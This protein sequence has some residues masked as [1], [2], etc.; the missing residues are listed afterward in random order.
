MNPAEDVFRRLCIDALSDK[1]FHEDIQIARQRLGIEVERFSKGMEKATVRNLVEG[2]PGQFLETVATMLDR[3]FP[4]LPD[5]YYL[6]STAPGP[7]GNAFVFVCWALCYD[8]ETIP[9]PSHVSPAVRPPVNPYI[10]TQSNIMALALIDFRFSIKN[11]LRDLG[12]SEEKISILLKRAWSRQL[13]E[14][15]NQGHKMVFLLEGS[16][17]HQMLEDL[18]KLFGLPVL[19]IPRHVTSTQ[20]RSWWPQIEQTRDAAYGKQ[21]LP[22]KRRNP[23]EKEIA[24]MFGEGKSHKQIADKLSSTDPALDAAIP[25]YVRAVQRRS[26]K[27]RPK[28]RE[29]TR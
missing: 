3:W 16:E 18:K 27:T 11:E 19:E 29:G 22:R 24:I 26:K 20:Y 14:W 5:E 9:I 21:T 12:W 23:Y 15:R 13:E 1:Q 25:D 7:Y 4:Q 8:L 17:D 28:R 6:R 2:D 10:T